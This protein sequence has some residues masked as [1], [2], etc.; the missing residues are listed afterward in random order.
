[1]GGPEAHILQFEDGAVQLFFSDGRPGCDQSDGVPGFQ[2]G[3]KD[4]Q[5]RSLWS[6]M[7]ELAGMSVPCGFRSTGA[8]SGPGVPCRSASAVEPGVPD[9]GEPPPRGGTATEPGC[10]V[11]LNAC[12]LRLKVNGKVICCKSCQITAHNGLLLLFYARTDLLE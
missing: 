5:S 2:S 6:P 3:R 12:S 8:G 10:Q 1:M 4:A 11:R 7:A 9:R